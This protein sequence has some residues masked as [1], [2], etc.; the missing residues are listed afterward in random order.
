MILYFIIS[1]NSRLIAGNIL[2][3]TVC[4]GS[5]RNI[6]CSSDQVINIKYALYGRISRSKCVDFEGGKHFWIFI[7]I[8]NSLSETKINYWFKYLLN[9]NISAILVAIIKLIS[10]SKYI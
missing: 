5:I 2:I 3:E 7:D 9:C 10:K 6:T 4:E 1:F 8:L